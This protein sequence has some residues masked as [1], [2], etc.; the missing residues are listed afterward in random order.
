MPDN[1]KVVAMRTVTIQEA[2]NNFS[3]VLRLVR[4]GEEV[5]LT[6]RK[7]TVA[8]ILTPTPSRRKYDWAKTWAKV[9]EIFGEKPLPGKPGS[10]I[11][12]EGRR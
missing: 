7:K 11:I 5:A 1:G 8:R 4:R 10:Q 12:I 9:D 2:E 6:S 3:G